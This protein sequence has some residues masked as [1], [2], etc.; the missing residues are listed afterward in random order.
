MNMK[1]RVSSSLFWMSGCSPVGALLC[2]ALTLG[3]FGGFFLP[4]HAGS[5][6]TGLK[7]YQQGDYELAVQ[8]FSQAIQEQVD[9]P[10]AHYYLAD[11]YLK[12]RRFV[13]AQAQYQKIL[14]M[15]PHSQA[16]RMSQMGL[17]SLN[18]YLLG[19]G[20]YRVGS[21][22]GSW[23]NSTRPDRYIGPIPT[24]GNYLNIILD[25]GRYVRWSLPKMPLRVYIDQSPQEVRNFEPSFV[26]QI[27]KALDVWVGALGNQ[28][29]YREV[30]LPD[31]ADIKVVWKNTIDTQGTSV[32]GG[33]SYTAGVTIP[34]IR[35]D[36]LDAME[37]TMATFDIEGKPQ[38]A[39]AIYEVAVH[40]LGHAMGLLGHSTHPG[41]IM[42]PENRGVVKPSQRDLTTLLTLYS[43][44]ADVTN[45]PPGDADPTR[46]KQVAMNL[47]AQIARQLN[48]VREHD[49]ALN[50]MNLGTAYFRKGQAIEKASEKA[51]GAEWYQKAADAFNEAV[52]R[53]PNSA[54]AYQKRSSAYQMLEKFTLS[55]ADIEKALSLDWRNSDLYLQQS[56]LLVNMQQYARA[57]SAL[58]TYLGFK[59]SAAGS[60]DV[61]LIQAKLSQQ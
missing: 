15:A 54:A 33:T 25:S 60:E 12:T 20:R 7:V 49:S 42:Y 30:S 58:N 1:K 47:D 35:N 17:S 2:G 11:S 37:L 22:T 23:G 56:W 55:L 18:D 9:N 61:K 27:R 52:K 21:A 26:N 57:R 38:N 51:S 29:S 6:E 34:R 16:A 14:A 36:Q 43:K 45:A 28:I 24:G 8:Y 4:A 19:T 53:E 10:N 39:K 48:T 5:Y 31:E 3:F 41:D 32:E 59:P 44:P 40:E 50:W 46:Q 13:E